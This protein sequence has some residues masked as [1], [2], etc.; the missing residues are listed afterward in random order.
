MIRILYLYTKKDSA[1]YIFYRNSLTKCKE[2][3]IKFNNKLPQNF[4]V[5]DFIFLQSN[6]SEIKNIDLLKNN[7][8]LVLVEPRYGHSNDLNLKFDLIIFNGLESKIFFSSKVKF[9]KSLIYPPYPEYQNTKQKILK[10]KKKLTITYHGNKVHIENSKKKI[11]DSIAKLS[12]NLKV[13]IEVNLIYNIKRLGLIK[14]LPKNSNLIIRHIQYSN[15]NIKSIL[16]FTDIGLVPQTLV[17]DN[18][19]RVLK[20]KD[21]ENFNL[22]FKHPTNIERHLVFAQFNIP[23]VTEPTPSVIKHF[24][25][26]SIN[27]LTYNSETWYKV[28]KKFSNN[29]KLRKKLGFKLY[30]LWF[31]NFRHK[32]LNEKLIKL[33]KN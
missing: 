26:E 31:K 5:Y 21:K 23:V 18:F 22:K 15:K 25:H 8:N 32:I 7:N 1:S 6:F 10:D 19:L 24:D 17:N 29:K 13:K 2:F 11:F 28:L 12:K 30:S 16:S 3:K 27:Y 9:K 4:S 14:F 33:L 20:K